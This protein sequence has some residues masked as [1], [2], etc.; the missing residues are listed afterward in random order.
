M[1]GGGPRGG[2]VLVAVAELGAVPAGRLR[3]QDP[4]LLRVPNAAAQLRDAALDPRLVRDW[5]ATSLA[6]SPG[7]VTASRGC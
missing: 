3:R 6:N 5:S 2:T 7:S 1:S 4:P